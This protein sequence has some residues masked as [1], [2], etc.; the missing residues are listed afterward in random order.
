MAFFTT[1][2]KKPITKIKKKLAPEKIAEAGLTTV[3][4]TKAVPSSEN[5]GG[6]KVIKEEI[7]V[8]EFITTPARVG[9]QWMFSIEVSPGEWQGLR[10]YVERPC[11][12][13]EVERVKEEVIREVKDEA[14]VQKR[15]LVQEV[16]QK[17]FASQRGEFALDG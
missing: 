14:E 3:V 1:S 9:A 2:K 17:F 10:L 4:R 15:I 13:E 16:S 11:Y 5:W 12:E 7:S 8:H 6:A